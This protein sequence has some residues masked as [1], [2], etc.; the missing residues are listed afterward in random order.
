VFDAL[1][2]GPALVDLPDEALSEQVVALAAEVERL[3]ARL[4]EAVAV[5]DGRRAWAADG[6][7]DPR[8]WLTHRTAM[9]R[10]DAN[11]LVRTARHLRR[12]DVT[13]MAL[14]DGD[15]QVPHVELLA[16]AASNGRDDVYGEHEKELLELA[17]SV[18]ARDFPVVAKRWRALADDTLAS[19]DAN[20]ARDR[21][22]LHVSTTFGGV[23]VNGFL[24]FDSGAVLLAGL[25]AFETFD[26]PD[27]PAPRRTASQRR[28]DALVDLV[29]LAT[30]GREGG[31]RPGAMAHV[32]VVLAPDR[33]EL[34]GVGPIANETFERLLCDSRVQRVLVDS[35]RI[36]VDLG[37]ATRTVSPAQRLA[38]RHRDGGCV[39]R[40]CDRPP[41]WCDAH[42][43]RPWDA[44]GATDLDNLVLL[45]RRHHVLVH[46]HQWHI[47]RDPTNGDVQ[48]RPPP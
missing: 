4:L 29:R 45:C 2:D 32:G 12:H 9:T 19:R 37:R 26:G 13:R 44:G 25:E 40:G 6:A 23:A 14:A 21:R 47:E 5:W 30:A 48:V 1:A 16:Q 43:L 34:D 38:L 36:R 17:A 39:F 8:A 10:H 20:S 31:H 7:V 11:R 42:H 28:V 3:Q 15:V 24:D 33:R 35:N 22:Y 27:D 41:N 46:E 18:T